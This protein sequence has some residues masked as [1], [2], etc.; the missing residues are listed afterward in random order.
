MGDLSGKL[1]TLGLEPMAT[2]PRKTYSFYDEHLYLVGPFTGEFRNVAS[3]ILVDT[4][5]STGSPWPLHCGV[6]H[7]CPKWSTPWLC[8]H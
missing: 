1:G 2:N 3:H 7:W 6:W 8:Q 4:F 5:P